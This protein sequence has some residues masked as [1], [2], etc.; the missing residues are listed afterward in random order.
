[1]PTQNTPQF[2]FEFYPPR[3][4]E[5]AVNLDT[6]QKQ[7]SQLNPEFFLLL[8][9]RVVQ[10]VIKHLKPLLAFKRKEFLR[11]HIYRVLHQRKKISVQF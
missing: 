6:V 11:H 4:S 9:V 7:L 10:R 2:S 1:M 5:G 3:T 8:L